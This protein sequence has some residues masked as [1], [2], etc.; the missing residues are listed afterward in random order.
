MLLG[1]LFAGGFPFGYSLFV[2]AFLCGGLVGVLLVQLYFRHRN[3]WVLLL[4]LRIPR[5]YHLSLAFVIYIA[6]FN[7]LLILFGRKIGL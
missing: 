6:L 3:I 4:N 2:N 1:I 7:L 5:F